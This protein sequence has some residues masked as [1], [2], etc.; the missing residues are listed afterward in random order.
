MK[1]KVIVG[2]SGGV[3]SSVAAYLLK[4]QGYE[5]EGLFM[6]NWDPAL[7]N[8]LA[9]P[10]VDK[11]VCQAEEDFQDAKAV[12][13]TLNIKLHRVNFVQE[14]WDKVFMY[15]LEEYKK[16]YTP[17]PDIF[18]NKYIK[19]KSFLDYA[20]ENFACDYIAMGHYA[21]V[22]HQTDTKMFRG[23]DENK[24]Q[25]YFLSQ[26]TKEQ[27]AK[28]LFPLGDLPKSEVRKIAKEQ[29]LITADK[30]DST[31]VCFIGERNFGLFLSSYLT[32]KVG[33]I[34]DYQTK[35][36]VGTHKGLFYYT[37]GQRKGLNI[38]GN[39]DFLPAPWLVVGK[40]NTKNELYVSQDNNYLKSNKLT[41]Q[42]VN[43]L[44]KD[45]AEITSVKVRYRSQ[46][47]KVIAVNK[48]SNDEI[49]IL[50]PE[51]EAVTP[52]QA[53]VFY[54]DEEC[55]GGAIIREVYQNDIK[56]EV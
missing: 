40:N 27:L 47:V 12:C 13:D 1:Q 8:D 49:E 55:L 26:L 45:I 41:A 44:G 14:Y 35:K 29:G 54:H 23:K 11:E 15:F 20:L 21:I 9:D 31:G 22:E 32:D 33:D 30:K 2:M 28:T 43:F 53:V 42:E 34:L 3:D 7:N 48:K 4:E 19:F 38:G 16:G 18:C 39:K 24:D 56:L 50:Y 36:K 17:N 10:Y 5:V 51:I 6:Q 25:T 37:I 46:D 52:G